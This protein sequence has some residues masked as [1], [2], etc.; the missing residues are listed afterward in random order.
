MLKVYEW[1]K[2]LILKLMF[3]GDYIWRVYLN[4]AY[5]ATH[6]SY[7]ERQLL[8]TSFGENVTRALDNSK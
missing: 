1:I 8:R 5:H 4:D 2:K 3:I 6:F 7:E